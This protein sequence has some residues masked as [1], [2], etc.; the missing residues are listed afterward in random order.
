MRRG[1]PGFKHLSHD[2]ASC[3]PHFTN[4]DAGTNPKIRIVKMVSY[5]A[6]K[7]KE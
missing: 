6:T 4:A 1:S 5:D 3:N 7:R 2:S